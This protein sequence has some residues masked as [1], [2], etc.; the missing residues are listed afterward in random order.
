ME[1]EQAT[2]ATFPQANLLILNKKINF[3]NFLI[4]PHCPIVTGYGQGMIDLRRYLCPR[5]VLRSLDSLCVRR[6]FS[7]RPGH[8]AAAI[9]APDHMARLEIAKKHPLPLSKLQSPKPLSGNGINK[10]VRKKTKS[11]HYQSH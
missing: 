3:L 6:P 10:T 4:C 1:G 9:I 5:I 8:R 11:G 2:A 7:E